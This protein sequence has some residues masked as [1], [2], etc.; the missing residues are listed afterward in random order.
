MEISYGHPFGTLIPV[1]YATFNTVASSSC[2][3]ARL[4][5]FT[6]ALHHRICMS[7]LQAAV[8]DK[9]CNMHVVEVDVRS[10]TYRRRHH[11]SAWRID[12]LA[13]HMHPKS[14]S[15]T[16]PRTHSDRPPCYFPFRLHTTPRS[17]ACS[18]DR[19][20]S[21]SIRNTSNQSFV[22]RWH[23]LFSRDAFRCHGLSNT[24]AMPDLSISY[25]VR[26]LRLEPQPC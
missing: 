18:L 1:G 3:C 17:L 12:P 24:N 9:G 8:S 5:Q 19:F 4:K 2:V 26:D 16:G 22:S 10:C 15:R 23:R 11:V 25:D 20:Q 21:A 7:R 14:P 6:K 13:H